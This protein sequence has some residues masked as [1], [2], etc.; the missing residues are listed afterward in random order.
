MGRQEIFQT[1]HYHNNPPMAPIYCLHL[2][3]YRTVNQREL[4]VKEHLIR[5]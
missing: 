3:S 5:C 2:N 4:L 1:R